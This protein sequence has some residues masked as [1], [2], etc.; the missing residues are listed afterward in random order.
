MTANELIKEVASLPGNEQAQFRELF[1]GLPL[2]GNG[3]KGATINRSAW[4]DFRER[5]NTIYGERVT[6][7]SAPIIDESR[8]ER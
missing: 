7:D 5:L 1:R 8:G 4:C 3:S 6:P 2:D